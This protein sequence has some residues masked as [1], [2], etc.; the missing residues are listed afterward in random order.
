MSDCD[1]CRDRIKK[2]VPAYK[3]VNGSAMCKGCYGGGMPGNP[4]HIQRGEV[5]CASSR[6]AAEYGNVRRVVR[7]EISSVSVAVEPVEVRLQRSNFL[8]IGWKH[9]VL[10][11]SHYDRESGRLVIQRRTEQ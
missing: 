10:L 8:R 6:Y 5:T 3:V 4:S 9:G 2:S 1:F 11:T 7:G